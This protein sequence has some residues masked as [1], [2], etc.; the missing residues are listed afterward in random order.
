MQ[1]IYTTELSRFINIMLEHND[2]FVPSWHIFKNSVRPEIGTVHS[3][4]MTNSHFPFLI[5]VE[6]VKMGMMRQGVRELS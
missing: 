5:I 2:P 1:P 6:S 4:L 3:Q